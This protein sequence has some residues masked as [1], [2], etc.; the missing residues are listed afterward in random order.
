MGSI[1][2]FSACCFLA[3]FVLTGCYNKP[4]YHLASDASLIKAG[5][6]SRQD[7]LM[8]LGEPDAQHMVSDDTE[9]WVYY[10]EDPSMMQKTPI[11]GDVFDA[12]GYGMIVLT[13]QGDAVTSCN[14]SSYDA[15]D[16][17]WSDDYSWQEKE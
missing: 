14:Y 8:L 11:I 17:S 12:K 1:I 15:G 9:E 5:K 16:F 2:R 4:V 6:S 13:L 3:L 7:V 10:E